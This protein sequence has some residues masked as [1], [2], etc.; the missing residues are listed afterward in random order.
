MGDQLPDII[1]AVVPGPVVE[2]GR[3]TASSDPSEIGTVIRGPDAYRLFLVNVGRRDILKIEMLAGGISGEDEELVHLGPVTK[4]FGRLPA[5]SSI[6]IG[7]L[8]PNELDFALW[9]DLDMFFDTQ[10]TK[11]IFE[12]YKSYAL[13]DEIKRFVP[14]LNADAYC[15]PV[16]ARG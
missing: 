12:I 1:A 7:E 10:A 8:T 11:T 2:A 3:I 15:F 6:M 4:I 14:T 16:R 5:G 9:F 13:R